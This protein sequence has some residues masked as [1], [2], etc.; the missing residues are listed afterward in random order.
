M[1]AIDIQTMPLEAIVVDHVGRANAFLTPAVTNEVDSKGESPKPTFILNSTDFIN[2]Q[3][4]LKTAFQLPADESQFQ[5]FYPQDS[6]EKFI[7]TDNALYL[8]G[9]VQ[10]K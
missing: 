6:F 10:L 9:M 4:Y 3:L 8:V 5:D 1:A 2:L 7:T